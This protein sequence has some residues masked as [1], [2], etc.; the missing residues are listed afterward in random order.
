MTVKKQAALGFVFITLLI[1]CIGLGIIIPIMP[2]L[3]QELQGGDLSQASIYGG[4]LTFAYAIFQFLFAPVVGGLSDRYGRRPVLLASLL[5][6]GVD[7]IFM[8]FAPSLAWLFV[9]RIIAG[10]F[11]A[12]FTT[13]MAYIADI[14]T[15]EKRAQ[16]FGLVGVAFGLGFIIGPVIG[17]LF[18]EFGLR[19][20]FM[21]AAGLSLLNCLYG[22]FILPESLSKRNRRR[23]EWKRANPIGALVHLKKYPALFSLV[24]A[25][26]LVYI[27]AHAAQ[28]TWSYYTMEKFNWDEKMV[29]YSL[30]LV[31]ILIAFVQ[32]G[33]IRIVIPKT[34]QK[35]AVYIG[36]LMYITGFVL[37]AFASKSWM[38]FAFCVPYCLGGIA[39]P[40]LQGILSTKVPANEQGELQGIMASMMSVSSILGPLLMTNL[41]STF[42]RSNAPVYFPGAPFMAGAIL[43]VI[44]LAL[45]VRSLLKYHT[46]AKQPETEAE[47]VAETVTPPGA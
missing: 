19:V 4:L 38:M 46:P 27:A 6:L 41:F 13:V 14:S 11:G 20:P 30:G 34:G 22:Y 2:G 18:A 3:I 15:P 35:N 23:F 24:F 26:L 42:T 12:S 28:S 17:G 5:G 21:V 1:D 32:G 10:I 40:A 16:N 33:L 29:G 44:S 7:Y 25:I 37:F 39:G 9:G 8:A 43:T 36:L 47:V 45:C 31:G